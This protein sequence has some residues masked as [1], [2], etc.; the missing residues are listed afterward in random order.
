MNSPVTVSTDLSGLGRALGELQAV[1]GGD[2]AEL[3]RIEAGQMA[4]RV[5]QDI[6]PV[7]AGK[8]HKTVEKNVKSVLSF[9]PVRENIKGTHQGSGDVKWLYSGKNFVAGIQRENDH[10]SATSAEA[11]RLYYAGKAK[12]G[13]DRVNTWSNVG[14]RGHQ[15]V[16]ILNRIRVA[17]A[18]FATVVKSIA[19]NIGQ[20]KASFAFATAQ[21]TSKRIPSWIA[22]HF[23]TRAN[24]KAIFND[25]SAKPN[26]PFVEFG[27]RAPGVVSNPRMTA[28]IENGARQSLKIIQSKVEKLLNGY[29]YDF[30]TGAVFRAKK[31]TF[32]R[33]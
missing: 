9:K 31:S 7:N 20:A 4:W 29:A 27:S 18:A 26:S 6:G 23:P 8:A 11:L 19:A 2:F 17:K 12:G 16:M 25:A 30:K 10:K 28:A 33:N 1:T 13:Y 14:T 5:A 32:E 22:K 15:S 24:G 3:T 21:T